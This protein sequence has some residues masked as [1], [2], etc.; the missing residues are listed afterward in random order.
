MST[1]AQLI[2]H[3]ARRLIVTLPL[4]YDEA[5]LEYEKLVPVVDFSRFFQLAT[6]Q[7]T[8]ELAEGRHHQVKRMIA[9]LGGH[10]E[11]LHRD[12]IGGLDLPGDLAAGEMRPLTQEER[13]RLGTDD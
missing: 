9:A 5:R 13:K 10:V 6:W 3:P 11:A 4:P 8:L 12:R 7:A 1:P 2:D